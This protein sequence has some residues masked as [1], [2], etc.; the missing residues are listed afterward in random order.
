MAG[1]GDDHQAVHRDLQTN[2][3]YTFHIIEVGYCSDLNHDEKDREK[4]QQHATLRELIRHEFPLA[5]IKYYT[6]PLGRSG[7]IPASLSNT[8]TTL[9]VPKPSATT[10]TENLHIHAIQWLERMYLHRLQVDAP[11]TG[12]GPRLPN[13]NPLK[14]LGFRARP[15][16]RTGVTVRRRHPG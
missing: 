7:T 15:G 14:T 2:P 1:P 13:L 9:G 10:C 8:L 12:D 4:Q 16:L 5:N 3:K 6:V 11:A